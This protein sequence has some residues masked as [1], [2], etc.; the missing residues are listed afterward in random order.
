MFPIL[1]DRSIKAIPWAAIRP[2]EKQA[3]ANHGG[4]TLNRLAQR[5]GLDVIEAEAAMLGRSV[6]WGGPNLTKK[7]LA[8]C[9]ANLLKLVWEYELANPEPE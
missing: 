6:N 8:R 5:G 3:M 9:R 4:Q 1:N 7:D 2:H